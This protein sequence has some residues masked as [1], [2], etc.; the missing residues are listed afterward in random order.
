MSVFGRRNR[1]WIVV[2]YSFGHTNTGIP[3]GEGLV[4][5]VRNDVDAKVFA[6]VELA[7]V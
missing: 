7:W 1:D 5:L 3:D 4:C 6:G 2:A